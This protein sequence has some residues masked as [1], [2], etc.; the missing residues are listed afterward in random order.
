MI[1][2]LVYQRN[3]RTLLELRQHEDVCD[4]DPSDNFKLELELED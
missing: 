3:F 4:V 2:S 1:M